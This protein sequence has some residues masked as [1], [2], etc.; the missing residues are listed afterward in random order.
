MLLAIAAALLAGLAVQLG[1]LWRMGERRPIG[2]EVNYLTRGRLADP[3]APQLFLRLPLLPWL[4]AVCQRRGGDGEKR[5][6]SLLAVTSFLT[7]VL[8]AVAGW[9]LGGPTLAF[10]AALLLAAQPERILIGC[11][12]WPESLI[13]FLLAALCAVHTL[14]ATPAL[15]LAM[16]GLATLGVLT[17]IDFAA[18]PPL[19]L[20]AW[21][22]SHGPPAVATAVALL[23]PPV[24][25]LLWVTVRNGRRYGIP[26]PENTWA[27]NLMVASREHSLDDSRPFEIERAV[28]GTVTTWERL[29]PAQ[30]TRRGSGALVAVLRSPW[31]FARGTWRRL[32]TLAGP[33]TFARQKLLP[34]DGAYPGLDP[35]AR[36]RWATALKIAFPVLV[37]I[38]LISF[39][40]VPRLPASFAWP[41]LGLMAPAVL[42]HAR[43]RYR[44]TA[45]P[46]LS[47]LAAQGIMRLAESLPGR[48]LAIAAVAVGAPLLLWALLRI[49]CSTEV[50]EPE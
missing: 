10:L 26:L 20:A 38:L 17:R 32:L 25:A 39:T 42:F 12:I 21:W 19:L 45:M 5:L 48:P 3:F 13:A 47:L 43:T 18:V 41:T 24:V 8:T 29:E 14:P 46:A 1:A 4:S 7:V 37:T 23:V 16:G 40:A 11:H 35:R 15:A 34:P 6:R 49:R 2:D 50:R 9:R 31:R 22:Q 44:V 36:R 27:F 30:V 28:A 33:D